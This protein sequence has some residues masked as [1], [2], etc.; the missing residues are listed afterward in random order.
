MQ[1]FCIGHTQR[2]ALGKR[3]GWV[4]AWLQSFVHLIISSSVRGKMNLCPDPGY[5]TGCE[6]FGAKLDPISASPANLYP[7][8]ASKR[9][10]AANRTNTHTHGSPLAHRAGDRRWDWAS[11]SIV[12][13]FNAPITSVCSEIPFAG[14]CRRVF[15]LYTIS[16]LQILVLKVIGQ[17][18]PT[19]LHILPLK[20]PAIIWS[21]DKKPECC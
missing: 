5:T 15:W 2:E 12:A 10:W 11:S 13:T 3:R 4:L 17:S 1:G 9:H 16:N 20:Q 21:L 8:V 7:F 18:T 19:S 14:K 6:C